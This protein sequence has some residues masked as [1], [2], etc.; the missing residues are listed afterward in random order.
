MTAFKRFLFGGV[1]ALMPIF[2][3]I[4][5]LDFVAL[6]N[7][8]DTF[9][10][11]N[12]AGTLI[13]YSVLF[14][15]GGFIAYLHRSESEPFKLFE[16][17][18]AAPAMI[19]ALV[20]NSALRP[21][22]SKAEDRTKTAFFEPATIF[23]LATPVSAAESSGAV[24]VISG[25]SSAWRQIVDG[26]TG[27]TYAKIGALPVEPGSGWVP[28]RG[29]DIP[30]GAVKGGNEQAPGSESL[31]VC[32]AALNDGIHP[33]KVRPA[34]KG[35]DVPWGGKELTI[36]DYQV[37]TGEY[38]WVPATDGS[39][40]TGA[41]L[42][43]RERPPGAEELFVCRAPFQ[44]GVHPGKVRASFKGCNV[45]WGGKEHT[46]GSYDVLVKPK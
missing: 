41:V 40:P 32:R 17:G 18:V 14:G 29:G 46:I 15:I 21:D 19:T 31:Y 4:V 34:F 35:C 22:L 26:F 43:G 42:G 9:T 16:L 28:A 25:G 23:L 13:R 24:H 45:S 11:W 39:I 10:P 6:A 30:A 7:R 44:E 20:A 36:A 2:L 5:T 38:R 27:K 33:G 3:T 37:L 1:G 12:I 8:S